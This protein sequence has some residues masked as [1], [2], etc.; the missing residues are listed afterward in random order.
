VWL[1]S[2]L[3]HTCVNQQNKEAWNILPLQVLKFILVEPI[4]F[5]I[6]IYVIGIFQVSTML[7]RIG[8]QVFDL[9]ADEDHLA[10]SASKA[11]GGGCVPDKC[12]IVEP[13]IQSLVKLL[14]ET[15]F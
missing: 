4:E 14:T 7:V 10:Y 15:F 6:Q 12:Q 8:H 2:Q 5:I 1:R 11:A 9:S 13:V 3:H